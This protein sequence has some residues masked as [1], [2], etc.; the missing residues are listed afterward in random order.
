MHCLLS[1]YSTHF[2]G[3]PL[4]WSKTSDNVWKATNNNFTSPR[5][6][7][8]QGGMKH[9]QS[10][11]KK[12]WEVRKGSPS[13]TWCWSEELKQ[14][15]ACVFPAAQS[16]DAQSAEWEQTEE[17]RWDQRDGDTGSG[18]ASHWATD[19]KS[20]FYCQSACLPASS[21]MHSHTCMLTH[22]HI[23]IPTYI[24]IHRNNIV[25]QKEESA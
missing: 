15:R 14:K 6:A 23:Y 9:R 2:R 10:C 1:E 11:K 19:R 21:H 7:C 12:S 24:Q 5:E 13:L 16:R 3:K 4:V 22:T 20:S 17:Q 8:N 25:A 18:L